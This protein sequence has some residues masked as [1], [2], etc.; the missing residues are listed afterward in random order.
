MTYFVTA[1]QAPRPPRQAGELVS[2]S[3]HKHSKHPEPE[4]QAAPP[5]DAPE[6]GGQDAA[7]PDPYVISLKREIAERDSRLAE[8]EEK[9]RFY[10]A[11]VDKV[12]SEYQASRERM[13]RENERNAAR[14]KVKLVG[15]LLG[16][17]DSLDR[18]LE[19]AKGG[20]VNGSF[21]AGVELIRNQLDSAL[22]A[23]GLVRFDAVGEAFDP[24]RHQAVTS[25]P[26]TD[27]AQAGRVLHC[28]AAGVMVGEEVVRAASVVV[29][30]GVA[31]EDVH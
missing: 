24:N 17:L 30:Q 21:V 5:E 3:Q 8:A 13:Q 29:G 12:R 10:A 2:V 9:V 7:D 4:M 14:E 19:S 25:M 18:S 27:P 6:A 16:V 31:S 23:L 26:V 11:S 28:V 20:E 15:G 1:N 22:S